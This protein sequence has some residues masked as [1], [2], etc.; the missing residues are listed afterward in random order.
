MENGQNLLPPLKIMSTIIEELKY[1]VYSLICI[2][3]VSEYYMFN[4]LMYG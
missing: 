1:L 3:C 4:F 2:L